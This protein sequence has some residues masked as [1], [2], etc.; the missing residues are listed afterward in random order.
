MNTQLPTA[1]PTLTPLTA[2]P[3]QTQPL[4]P[5]AAA[6]TSGAP[7]PP[8][9]PA[10]SE[11]L[12]TAARISAAVGRMAEQIDADHRGR[13]LLAVVILH[14]GVVFAGDLMRRLQRVN[15]RLETV[16]A[17]SYVGTT[18]QAQAAGPSVQ[19]VSD[20]DV[21]G[22]DVLVLDDIL[23]TGRTLAAVRR[24]LLARGAASIS[25]A[26]LLDKPSR[27]EVDVRVEYRGLVVPDVFVVGYGLDFD[28]RWRN[29]PD[30]VALGPVHTASSRPA[31]ERKPAGG[32]AE[33]EASA[34]A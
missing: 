3:Q 25:I 32:T 14:G 15:L 24:E 13:E 22:R 27:R 2:L 26:V 20:L 19:A 7:L 4:A 11:V 18:S 33:A 28:G 1:R 21:A 6:P 5:P 16:L 30:I 31:S 34:G 12:F 8:G 23:D 17:R 10:G 9:Y 29:L